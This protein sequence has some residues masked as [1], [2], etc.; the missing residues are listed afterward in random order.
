MGSRPARLGRCGMGEGGLDRGGDRDKRL[1][2]A[3][4][5]ISVEFKLPPKG[6]QGRPKGM[7]MALGA[8]L[9]RLPGKTR[10]G[11]IVGRREQDAQEHPVPQPPAPPPP[12]AHASPEAISAHVPFS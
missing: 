10:Q 2:A 8:W 11:Y 1:I 5:Y 4:Q 12:H 9:P 3:V 6:R 7:D